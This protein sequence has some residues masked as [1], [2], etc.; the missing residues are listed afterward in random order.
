MSYPDCTDIILIIHDV[1]IH[2]LYG[3]AVVSQV[4]FVLGL[5]KNYLDEQEYI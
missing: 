3:R 2:R 4:S 5:I 1:P